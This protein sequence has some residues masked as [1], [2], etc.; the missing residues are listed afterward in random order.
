MEQT[1]ALIA[2]AIS[3]VALL[4]SGA[5]LWKTWLQPGKLTATF[6]SPTI[7]AIG[8]SERV[9]TVTSTFDNSGA[10]EAVVEDLALALRGEATGTA[11]HWF[12]QLFVDEA[13]LISSVGKT[14]VRDADKITGTWR[15][16]RVPARSSATVT[17]GLVLDSSHQ[18]VPPDRYAGHVRFYGGAGTRRGRRWHVSEEVSFNLSEDDI[19]G[20]KQ[21]TVIMQTSRASDERRKALRDSLT[22]EGY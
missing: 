8:R 15:P 16:V 1:P 6:G 5:S 18:D 4:V 20:I 12:A 2:I 9:V 3:V 17:V 7:G 22:A 10:H 21:G 19:E 11:T 14:N 13:V